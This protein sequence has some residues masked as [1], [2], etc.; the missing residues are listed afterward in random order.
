[1]ALYETTLASAAAI[2]ARQ[3]VLTSGASVAIGDTIRVDGELFQVAKGYVAAA[4]IVPVL[5]GQGGTVAT[6]HSILARVVGGTAA[7]FNQTTSPQTNT[8]YP[9]AGRAR[10]VVSYGADGAIALPVAGNDTL[11]LLSGTVAL[12]MTLAVPTKDLDGTILTCACIST[13]AHVI[14]VA[15][16]ISGSASIGTATFEASPAKCIISFMALDE[17]W[18]L[19]PGPVSGTLTSLDIALST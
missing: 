7:D 4:T 6:A 8:L 13:G 10:N 5:R 11:V 19:Y 1:M 3:L 17:K 9:I 12:A 18:A 2:D 16:G 15:G 14:T